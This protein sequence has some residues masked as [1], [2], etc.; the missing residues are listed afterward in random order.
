MVALWLQ[1]GMTTTILPS[2]VL[3]SFILLLMILPSW[4][5]RPNKIAVSAR[6]F[7][8]G[9]LWFLADVVWFRMNW[10]EYRLEWLLWFHMVPDDFHWVQYGRNMVQYGCA[11]VAIWLHYGWNIVALWLRY[12]CN[13]VAIWLQYCCTMVALLLHYGCDMD[14]LWLQYC[15][16]I[17][18]QSK[19]NLVIQNG[20]PHN[21]FSGVAIQADSVHGEVVD[22]QR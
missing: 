4:F 18:G 1:H 21:R 20:T 19:V 16:N 9:P 8:G 22:N 17:V 5:Y 7:S 10:N 6:I 15:C 12:G 2:L 14:A 13:I 11:M 3:S